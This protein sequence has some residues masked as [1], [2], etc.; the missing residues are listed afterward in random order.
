MRPKF[1]TFYYNVHFSCPSSLPTQKQWDE[2][3][4]PKAGQKCLLLSESPYPQALSS[5]DGQARGCV[6]P[7]TYD[8]CSCAGRPVLAPMQAAWLPSRLGGFPS[9]TALVVT[10]TPRPP[11]LACGESSLC[12]RTAQVDTVTES[13]SFYPKKEELTSK[14]FMRQLG[15]PEKAG[16]T[17][18]HPLTQQPLPRHSDPRLWFN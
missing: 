14:T 12:P 18:I 2:M 8:Q 4:V 1:K 3:T 9:S 13:T 16:L 7:R 10:S 11:F 5:L 17:L 15:P 6:H